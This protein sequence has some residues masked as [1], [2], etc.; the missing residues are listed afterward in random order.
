MQLQQ[1]YQ[2]LR[3]RNNFSDRIAK[4]KRKFE[5]KP[6]CQE[7]N[8]L[9]Q[10]ATILRVILGAFSII[11]GFG[12]LYYSINGIS[13]I[14]AGLLAGIALLLIEIL[15]NIFTGSLFTKIYSKSNYSFI[16][17]PAI[18]VFALSVYFSIN[19]ASNL[20]REFDNSLVLANDNHQFKLDSIDK[21]YTDLINS[22]KA[23]EKEFKQSVSWKNKINIYNN[24][25]QATLNRYNSEVSELLENKERSL[26]SLKTQQIEISN[27]LSSK[28][29]FNTILW[30]YISGSVEVCIILC[31][32]FITYYDYRLL[33]DSELF[34]AE[35]NTFNFSSEEV[36]RFA[37]L[38]RFNNNSLPELPI[39]HNPEIGFK[40]ST[41]KGE[42]IDKN[43][44][45][46]PTLKPDLNSA[47]RIN[48]SQ[49]E[50]KE[51][52]QKYSNVVQCINDGYSNKQTAKE[53]DISLSTVH[54]VKRCLKSLEAHN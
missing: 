32:W 12:F 17:L 33:K 42:V 37:E 18:L 6:F 34:S 44:Y 22:V 7:Y 38:I 27:D 45:L 52:L 40:T 2:K 13:F 25:I 21:H 53:C 23:E 9:L 39:N 8:N 48:K 46:N 1:L 15:K 5:F 51:F 14:L 3:E 36:Q 24:T 43:P 19:G 4:A 49:A 11:T 26:E 47:N 50:L 54:N 29:E 28:K 20:Y 41:N 30:L 35:K 10:L 31:L 16:L